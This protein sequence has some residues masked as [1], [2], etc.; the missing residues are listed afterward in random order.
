MLVR[1]PVHGMQGVLEKHTIGAFDLPL[2]RAALTRK[3][4]LSMPPL[5]VE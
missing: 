2:H 5:R 1:V 3:P 4:S